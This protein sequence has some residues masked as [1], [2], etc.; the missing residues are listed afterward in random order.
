MYY[1]KLETIYK[2]MEISDTLPETSIENI[3]QFIRRSVFTNSTFVSP[4]KFAIQHN[5][6]VTES[7]KLFMHLAG[8]NGIFDVIFYFECSK[9]NCFSNRIYFEDY[10]EEYLQCDECLN[11]YKISTIRPYI[12][13]LFKLKN[14]INIPKVVKHIKK[15]NRNS[16]L[17][18]LEGLPDHLKLVSPSSLNESTDEGDC[19]RG[20]DIEHAI[21]LNKDKY[22]KVINNAIDHFKKIFMEI[23]A[24]K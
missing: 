10:D 17:Q 16:T 8:D 24:N 12:K 23:N 3:D 11:K 7:V 18:A 2:N 1:K 19:P 9:I 15:V 4:Y 22:G 20:I 5:I 13:V 21:S 6:T 14:D